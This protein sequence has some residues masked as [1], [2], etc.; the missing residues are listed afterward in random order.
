MSDQLKST[1]D[2]AMGRMKQMFGEKE[3]ALTDD[4]KRRI[5]EVRKEYEAKVAEKKILLAGA[6]EL[7]LELQEL[8]R[9]KEQK[10]KAIHQEGKKEK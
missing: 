4:Q 2:V 9:E 1:L 3:N 5:A 7:S 6:E 8:N 10:I